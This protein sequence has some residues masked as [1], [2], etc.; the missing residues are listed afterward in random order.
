MNDE[1][2]GVKLSGP[3]NSTFFTEC[4][5]TAVLDYEEKCPRCNELV[6][7]HDA[8]TNPERWR[9]RWNYAFRGM[10]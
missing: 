2:V 6:I 1:V 8:E 4:C 7:G 3:N 5:G 9:I 10:R